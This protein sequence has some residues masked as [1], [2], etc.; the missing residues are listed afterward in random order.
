[1]RTSL[2]LSPTPF[3][4]SALSYDFELLLF[5]PPSRKAETR[6]RYQMDGSLDMGPRARLVD[7][8]WLRE[9]PGKVGDKAM[10]GFI[11]RVEAVRHVG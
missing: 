7:I 3:F 2:P 11:D 10:R 6:T 1:M 5:R 8:S 4:R 9:S